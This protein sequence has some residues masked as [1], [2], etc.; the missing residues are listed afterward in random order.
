MNDLNLKSFTLI[1]SSILW[2]RILIT[3]IIYCK[4]NNELLN[5]NVLLKSLNY[6]IYSNTGLLNHLKPYIKKILTDGFL[7]PK[8]Y[9]KCIYL[10]KGIKMYSEAYRIIN[11]N[12]PFKKLNFIIDFSFDVFSL[13]E[14]SVESIDKESHDIFKL[15]RHCNLNE[16]FDS[17]TITNS[18]NNS[19]ESFTSTENEE[20][21]ENSEAFE[22]DK[23]YNYSYNQ[24]CKLCFLMNEW[25]INSDL[26]LVFEN[27]DSSF[28]DI[29]GKIT[30]VLIAVLKSC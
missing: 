2:R 6:N 15:L 16:T 20:N 13:N 27:N 8:L 30:D 12:D 25:N 18:L 11:E 10:S 23:K 3:G 14:K 28:K 22:N 5:K 21:E 29:Q 19:F 7:F 17:L 9:K 4:H 1:F 26:L 24:D